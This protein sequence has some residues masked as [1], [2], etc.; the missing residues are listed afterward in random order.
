V[1]QFDLQKFM[2]CYQRDFDA[3]PYWDS[4]RFW[5]R[6]L[7]NTSFDHAYFVDIL[8]VIAGDCEY[9]NAIVNHFVGKCVKIGVV[10]NSYVS[11]LSVNQCFQAF[12]QCLTL[13]KHERKL[14]FLTFEYP[15]IYDQFENAES[16][17]VVLI[18]DPS[19][20]TVVYV[21]SYGSTF[22]HTYADSWR[23]SYN[24]LRVQF[25]DYVWSDALED[26]IQA[27]N[28]ND[29]FCQTWSLIL[30]IEVLLLWDS[31]TGSACPT[32]SEARINAFLEERL[33][34]GDTKSGVFTDCRKYSA[35]ESDNDN[36]QQKDNQGAKQ[37]EDEDKK[38]NVEVNT[39]STIT[40]HE[41]FIESFT[42][43]KMAAQS[44]VCDLSSAVFCVT[45]HLRTDTAG[46][47]ASA[48]GGCSLAAARASCQTEVVTTAVTGPAVLGTAASCGNPTT[49]TTS[50]TETEGY[51]RESCDATNAVGAGA[52][53]RKSST[54]AGKLPR[55]S[56]FAPKCK[57]P[58]S[59]LLRG[60]AT[61]FSAIV[62]FWRELVVI[63][64]I[65]EAVYQEVYAQTHMESGAVCYNRYF[66][67][68][69]ALVVD[70]AADDSQ[71]CCPVRA[72][73]H[74]RYPHGQ[75]YDR[76]GYS[77]IEDFV[78]AIDAKILSQILA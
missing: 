65:R 64:S 38:E 59:E 40:S 20:K 23:C 1:F 49:S 77:F 28:G 41:S 5:A 51:W 8:K 13:A 34:Q 32:L 67:T 27:I 66:T 44:A 55:D 35:L 63:P 78:L 43:T 31:C 46:P 22:A 69:E 36:H 42:P 76:T 11:N 18:A 10:C 6:F 70:E 62:A 75:T 68:L 54:A 7:Q 33:R 12:E 57:Y 15:C 71:L 61:G 72:S 25:K 53:H 45:D 26:N 52:Q 2:L 3:D 47:A 19:T 39:A 73:K 4:R 56:T 17:C 14:T 60:M 29:H 21:D 37:E 74:Y 48:T 58:H 9:R 30:G 16:H 50:A 24:N